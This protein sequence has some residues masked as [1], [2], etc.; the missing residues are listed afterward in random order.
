[1]LRGE[2]FQVAGADEAT[3]DFEA[4]ERAEVAGHVLAGDVAGE[5]V[6][7]SHRDAVGQDLPSASGGG[8]SAGGSAV[9][10]RAGRPTGMPAR[11]AA[12]RC[13]G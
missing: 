13:A 8:E 9:T 10:S 5:E 2:L 6:E 4:A 3:V 11:F 12:S 7:L 1:V